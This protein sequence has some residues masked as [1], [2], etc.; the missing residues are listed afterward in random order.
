MTQNRLSPETRKVLE[1]ILA[2]EIEEAEKYVYAQFNERI[3]SLER[4]LN[5]AQ[6]ERSMLFNIIT[7]AK[8]GT[9]KAIP[10]GMS[11]HVVVDP[12][13]DLITA[14]VKGAWP[15]S[16]TAGLDARRD[17]VHNVALGVARERDGLVNVQDVVDALARQGVSLGVDKPNTS[18]GN[19]L[20]RSEEWKR[21]GPA[22]FRYVGKQLNLQES[23]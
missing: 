21:E 3:A 9:S 4:A 23:K 19:L 22:V 17:I 7:M 8:R 11:H 13:Y 1:L 6:H 18:V 14:T 2:E 5:E 16:S 15:P 10:V 20:H 12:T